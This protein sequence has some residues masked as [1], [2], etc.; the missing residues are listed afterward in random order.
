MTLLD[1]LFRSW[2]DEPDHDQLRRV[3]D[4]PCVTVLDG[5][6]QPIC[7][8]LP[9]ASGRFGHEV[10]NPIPVNGIGGE[11][12]YLNTLRARSGVGLLYHR[13]GSLRSPVSP[14]PVDAYDVVA[15]DASQWA[16]L[17]FAMYHPR[18]SRDVPEG[19]TRKAWRELP[20]ALRAMAYVAGTGSTDRVEDFP[21]GLPAA[22]RRSQTLLE[23]S[24]DEAIAR[25]VERTLAR[26]EGRW[27]RPAE[28]GS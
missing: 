24:L 2:R 6:L 12:A 8:R 17:Y 18:R 19:F 26:N 25:M 27:D 5:K 1:W 20:D 10:T 9:G 14:L 16:R 21:F 28:L 13:L 7:D 15:V 22:L 4:D 3:L 23:L 11:V